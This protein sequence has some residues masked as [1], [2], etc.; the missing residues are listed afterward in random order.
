MPIN[1]PVNNRKVAPASLAFERRRSSYGVTYVNDNGVVDMDNVIYQYYIDYEYNFRTIN[2]QYI[3]QNIY[4]ADLT[5]ISNSITDAETRAKHFVGDYKHS[6]QWDIKNDWLF[7][8]DIW[9][10][11]P[12]NNEVLRTQGIRNESMNY[13]PTWSFRADESNAGVW[14]IY[15]YIQIKFGGFS[16]IDEARLAIFVNGALY[17]A[18]D[19]V[20]HHDM[21]SSSKISD[22]HLQGGAHVPLRTGDKLEICMLT[23][24]TISREGGVLYPSSIYGYVTAHRENCNINSVNAPD[25]GNGYSFTKGSP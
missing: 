12:F 7:Y 21:G 25:T 1:D 14:W 22:C 9:T 23:K 13:S 20:D 24:D 8:T 10:P 16:N 18:I 5:K 15:S 19:M 6:F 3:T 2:N 4:N 11:V 17:R